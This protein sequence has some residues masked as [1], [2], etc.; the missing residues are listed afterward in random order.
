MAGKKSAEK[1]QGFVVV[2]D[3]CQASNWARAYLSKI[4]GEKK[5]KIC[6]PHNLEILRAV[7]EC[8]VSCWRFVLLTRAYPVGSDREVLIQ[9]L[10]GYYPKLEI[11][12]MP[13][14]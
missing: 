10:K 1:P 12:Y 6:G 9:N 7:E 13:C 5:E 4:G 3:D 2:A 11:V 8:S 14:S